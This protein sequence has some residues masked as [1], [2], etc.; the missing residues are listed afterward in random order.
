MVT[1]HFT[2]RGKAFYVSSTSADPYEIVKDVRRQ[3]VDILSQENAVEPKHLHAIIIEVFGHQYPLKGESE[4][5]ELG[6]FF[7]E[8]RLRRPLKNQE[9][10]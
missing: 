9:N 2:V 4:P 6:E 5:L 8:A 1:F 3:I 10:H 7:E